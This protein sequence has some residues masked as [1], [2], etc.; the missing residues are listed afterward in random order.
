MTDRELIKAELQ[1]LQKILEAKADM[2]IGNG[3][4]K[5]LSFANVCSGALELL[6]E[7]EAVEPGI[8]QAVDGIYATCGNCKKKLWKIMGLEFVVNPNEM[9]R[10]CQHCGRK[11]KWSEQPNEGDSE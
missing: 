10:F 4:V 5:L 3:K 9:P 11:V 1:N 8:A 7:Q 2:C 6:K